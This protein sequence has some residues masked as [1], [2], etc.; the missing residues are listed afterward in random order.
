MFNTILETLIDIHLETVEIYKIYKN[1]IQNWAYY[2]A[3]KLKKTS[4]IFLT[5]VECN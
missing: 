1:V 5:C 2:T 3:F 4:R